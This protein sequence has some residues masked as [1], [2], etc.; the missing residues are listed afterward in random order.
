MISNE[1]QVQIAG[2]ACSNGLGCFNTSN[3]E[4]FSRQFPFKFLDSQIPIH[5]KEFICV[6]ISTKLW[7]KSWAGKRVEIVPAKYEMKDVVVTIKEASKRLEVI[8]LS[9]TQLP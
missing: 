2:D 7:G 8:R 4:Y 6:I 3:K 1:I 9:K 5:L